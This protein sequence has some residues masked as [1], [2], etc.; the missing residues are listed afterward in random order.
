MRASEFIVEEQLD[1][2]NLKKAIATGALA[3]AAA[4]SSMSP[5]QARVNIDDPG[6]YKAP[7]PVQ[8]AQAKIDYTKPG[9]F[10][11][12]SLGQKLEYGIPVTNDGKFKYP[13]QDLP[14]DE[15]SQQ[16]KA[17]KTWKADFISRWPNAVWNSD[18]SVKSS[19]VNGLAPM[20]PGMSKP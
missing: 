12:D 9:P 18:G 10:T 11:K 16:L 5:A 14:D 8:V 17:Y 13:N 19:G 2:I 3:G 20:Y 15:F 7:Q 4:L 6:S 1:E